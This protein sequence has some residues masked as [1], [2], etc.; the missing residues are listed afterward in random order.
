MSVLIRRCAHRAT[1]SPASVSTTSCM[2]FR[3][4]RLGASVRPSKGQLRS[5]WCGKHQE[6]I[7]SFRGPSTSMASALPPSSS[8]KE[9]GSEKYTSGYNPNAVKVQLSKTPET[10]AA[11]LL[12]YLKPGQVVLDCG[13]GAGGLSLGFARL[14]SPG[15]RLDGVDMEDSMVQLAAKN[16]EEAG[17]GEVAKFHKANVYSLPFADATYDVITGWGLLLYLSDP[18][19][20]LR[21][22]LRMLKPGGIAAF[23]SGDFGGWLYSPETP[24]IVAAFNYYKKMMANDGGDAHCGRKL[25]RMIAE[26]GLE[27]QYVGYRYDPNVMP[28]AMAADHFSKRIKESVEKDGA[29]EKGWTTKEEV[30][31]MLSGLEEFKS[32]PDP[33]FVASICE[34][35]GRKRA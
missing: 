12:P 17:F 25:K 4:E 2:R 26:A 7:R 16:A 21:E 29:V 9:A 32:D 28:A 14:V 11:F 31:S 13:C 23:I 8:Q 1:K 30:D 27:V 24:G 22:L 19:K 6:S 33:V 5:S 15:G 20:A 34:V 3:P 35:L 10:Q 18:Q